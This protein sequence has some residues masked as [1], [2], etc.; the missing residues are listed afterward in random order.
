MDLSNFSSYIAI[1]V[2]LNLGYASLDYFREQLKSNIFKSNNS[3]VLNKLK[4]RLKIQISEKRDS[5]LTDALCKIK[6]TLKIQAKA[7]KSIEKG[8][9]AFFEILRP[10]SLLLSL[11]CITFLFVA[12][13]QSQNN[14]SLEYSKYI[15]NLTSFV[16]I[17]IYTVFCSS[18]LDKVLQNKLKLT[19]FQIFIVF[20]ISLI[21]PLF[22]H[23]KYYKI[24]FFIL[25]VISLFVFSIYNDNIY[26]DFSIKK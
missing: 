14:N 11:L 6:E 22:L 23:F 25:P 19:F 20:I 2:G 21:V 1:F 3:A 4:S 5:E 15:F 24:L 12:G 7:L 17:F 8:D 13:F 18:F 26:H 9:R 10:I 16:G